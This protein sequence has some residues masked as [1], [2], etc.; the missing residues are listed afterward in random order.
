ME[1]IQLHILEQY[2]LVRLE[3]NVCHLFIYFN[4]QTFDTNN[5]KKNIF[6]L[7][8]NVSYCLNEKVN[9]I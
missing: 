7:F 9:S 5:N 3:Y 2:Y 4:L 6:L 1:R 8:K